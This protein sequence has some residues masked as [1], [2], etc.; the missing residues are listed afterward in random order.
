MHV[1]VHIGMLV[2]LLFVFN[3]CIYLIT[4]IYAVSKWK[5][6]KNKGSNL[7]VHFKQGFEEGIN[8]FIFLLINSFQNYRM[9]KYKN[10]HFK[11][12]KFHKYN[13]CTCSK[14]NKYSIMPGYLLALH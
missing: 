13:L 11:G 9:G 14:W 4:V 7:F 1:H 8:L 5:T 10:F 3:T 12:Q 2:I 6:K